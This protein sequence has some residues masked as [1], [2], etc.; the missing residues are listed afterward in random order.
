MGKDINIPLSD[1]ERMNTSLANIIEEFEKAGSR[2][3]NLESWIGSPHGESDLR[4]EVDRFEGAWDDKRETLREHLVTLKE[5]VVG[6]ADGW[7]EFD[8]N[9]A[10]S[11]DTTANAPQVKKRES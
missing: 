2:G 1:L 10:K 5:R 3:N 4:H 8:A 9:S 7:T 11:L 6:V